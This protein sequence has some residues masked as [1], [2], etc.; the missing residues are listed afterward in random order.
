MM[1][2]A[3]I[4][5]TYN[6]SMHTAKVIQALSKNTILPAKLYIFQDG[7]KKEEH[8]AEWEKVNQLNQKIDF[9]PTELHV[10]DKNCGVAATIVSGINFVM[11][12]HDAVI[13]IEDDCLPA[14]CF[15]DFMEQCLIKYKDSQLVYSISG[16]KWPIDIEKDSYDVY[17]CGRTSSWGWGTWKDRW[18]NFSFDN[19]IIKRLKKDEN[20]SR[21]LATWGDDCEKMLLDN[22]AGRI[23]AWDIYWTLHVFENNGI[24][25]NP[26]EALIQNIG[27]DGS[28]VHCGEDE[29]FWVELS[30]ERKHEFNLPQNINILPTTKIAFAAL[31]GNY[32]A[33]KEEEK[34]KE[35]VIVYG[36]GNFFKQNEKEINKKYYI[37]AFVDRRRQGWYAGKKLIGIEEIEKYSYDKIIIMVQNIQDCM[38]VAKELMCRK[39][40]KEQIIIGHGIYGYYSK[41]IDNITILRDGRLLLTMGSISVVISSKEEFDSVYEA[42]VKRVYN[43]NINNGKKDVVIDV[44]MGIG[45]GLLYFLGKSEVE[46]V[47]GVEAVEESFLAAKENLRVYLEDAGKVEIF[48]GGFSYEEKLEEGSKAVGIKKIL[49]F[50]ESISI[51][52]PNHN[53]ILKVG[54]QDNCYI[55]KGLSQYGL[56]N[57]INVVMIKCHVEEHGSIMKELGRI[58]FAWR[59]S[60]VSGGVSIIYAHNICREIPV[61]E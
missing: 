59:V 58:G 4:L 21:I 44:G 39:V 28:G 6:R 19:D 61:Q 15:I 18:E 55:L 52:Y 37:K 48:Q 30:K 53:V 12:R 43:Y 24:C 33:V 56:W 35:N 7:L 17:G 26:Y 36:L 8:R 32:T 54:L 9:C 47:Y 5:F 49:Q 11:K 22:V 50:F 42:L 1:N 29:R 27:L 40:L 23:D 16:Y 45:D 51:N 14:P 20:K 38:A 10:S 41:R 31:F 60:D 25:I 34:S 46:K 2:I 57:K 3:A 13:V